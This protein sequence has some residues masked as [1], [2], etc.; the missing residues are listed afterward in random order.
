MVFELSP[1]GSKS[2]AVLRIE[3]TQQNSMTVELVPTRIH[4]DELG[5]ETLVSA[6]EDFL[7][8]PP[9]TLIEPGKTQ[10][11]RVNYIG[12]PAINSSQAYRISVKQLPVNLRTSGHTG[13]GMVINFNTL[14]NVVP[15]NAA[16]ELSVTS[17]SA[18]DEDTWDIA[19]SNTGNRFQ[20]LSKT[21]WNVI[22][23]VNPSNTVRLKSLEVGQLTERNLVLPGSTL[24]M[25][26]P[27]IEGF[28]PENVKIE[29]S[30][31]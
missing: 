31:G 5:N 29:I 16:P 10:V 30:D 19:I 28:S 18:N 12:E 8:Y 1:T 6:E 15:D 2:S 17:I 21:V 9:Q 7:I 13:V 3:N 23:T 25:S 4:M 20:R 22:D 11:V 14:L 27:S 24:M 26:I